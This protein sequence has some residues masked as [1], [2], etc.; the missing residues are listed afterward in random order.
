[1]YQTIWRRRILA[2]VLAAAFCLALA[3]CGSA[4]SSATGEGGADQASSGQD[5]AFAIRDARPA[6]D[7][8]YSEIVSGDAGSEPFYAVNPNDVSGEAV[9]AMIG[10]MLETMGLDADTLDAYAFSMSMMNV[11]AYA[12]GVFRPVKDKAQDVQAALEE[13]VSLQQ[14]NFNQY[15]E[16]QYE[17]AKDAQ[18]KTL[19]G[20]EIVLVMAE[21]AGD[22]LDKLESALS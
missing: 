1:M 19:P 7:N 10:M 4:P 18:I 5:Y 15:L 21:N 2:L 8:E 20:G 14:Q 13:Y 3:G 12:I 11:R 9:S 22:I 6:E 17:I 16:D